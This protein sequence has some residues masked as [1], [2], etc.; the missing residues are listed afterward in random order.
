[1]MQQIWKSFPRLL[2]QQ[3][4]R[5][6]DEAVPNPAK[7]FQIYKTC[8]S[9]NLWNESFEKFLTRL[10]Q[11]CSVPRIERS[12]GQF[13]RFL[14]RP[15]DSDTYQNFHLTFR[16]AQVEASEVRNI[17]S[18]AHHMMRINLKV[19]QENV[20][21]A[22]LEKTLFRLTNPSVLEKDLDFEFSDFCEAWKTVLGTMLDETKKVQ[23]HLLLA[24]LRQLDIQS[25]K[26]DA[27]ISRDVT[28][29]AERIYFT[30][31]EIDWT[32]QVRR[33][34][35]TYGVMPK[36]PLRNGPEKIYLI[37]L[38]KMVTLH[39]LAQLSEKPEIIEHRENIR[40]TIL[41]RCDFLLSVKST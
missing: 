29:V 8:Q 39:G 6:L 23:L 17:A 31:T 1:M 37:E 9:E 41:D 35:F 33:A 30:Q 40:I 20:S 36:Y 19:D 25:K 12:K 3:V 2:E 5:L 22:V 26:A 10:N 18:W 11:F 24:E 38:Q 34:A 15:M 14:Q 27:E 32:S 28:Q 7:A 16:T 21:I 13:D 4:N